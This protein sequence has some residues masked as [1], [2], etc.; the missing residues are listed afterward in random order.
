L[1]L[2]IYEHFFNIQI[3]VDFFRNNGQYKFNQTRGPRLEKTYK[4][5]QI[6]KEKII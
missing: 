4:S 3:S 6:L 5:N 1:V 2:Q